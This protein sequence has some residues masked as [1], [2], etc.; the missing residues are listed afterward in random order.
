MAFAA[1]KFQDT[2]ARVPDDI[3]G[4]VSP[5]AK[6]TPQ[7]KQAIM[8]GGASQVFP[9]A[10]TLPTPG[11]TKA[12]VMSAYTPGKAQPTQAQNQGTPYSAYAPG[13]AQPVQQ[14][15]Y[16]TPYGF[17][18]ADGDGQ[19]DRRQYK[20]ADEAWSSKERSD[21][22]KSAASQYTKLYNKWS[23]SN[24]RGMYNPAPT[25]GADTLRDDLDNF[26]A[27]GKSADE[28][29]QMI[30]LARAGGT[31]DDEDVA[32]AKD[33][34]PRAIEKRRLKDIA[35][36]KIKS[37][38]F[39]SDDAWRESIAA[40]QY[41]DDSAVA[42]RWSEARKRKAESQRVADADKAK[43]DY[44]SSWPSAQTPTS[45]TPAQVGGAMP[46]DLAN[47]YFAPGNAQPTQAQNQGTPY[48]T[49]PPT[50]SP[51]TSYA[52]AWNAAMPK[53]GNGV[54]F[55][56]ARSVI[57]AGA[58]NMAYAAPDKRPEGF[59][60]QSYDLQGNPVT[61]GQQAQQRDAF[62]AQILQA[63]RETPQYDFQG[64]LGRAGDMVKD[65]WQ[66]PFNFAAQPQSPV[67]AQPQGQSS[68]VEQLFSP[69]GSQEQAG[70]F[71]QLLA[72][73]GQSRRTL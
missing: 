18:D 73:L 59:V 22:T 72:R 62:I 25:P 30:D 61:Q 44:F 47:K 52:D 69:A 15:S 17:P 58:G 45:E 21:Q 3:A 1:G 5:Y 54:Q 63:P 36:G 2:G 50:G 10:P 34:V 65:G 53:G 31:I 71:D 51:A 4:P 32:F 23:N 56:P 70:Y 49:L 20:T 43:T 64:M 39:S 48:G 67:P 35:N 41:A 28:L 19:D 14:Q 33:Y 29:W 42:D 12:P 9:S 24:T 40:N 55:T 27:R 57:G 68:A 11:S 37:S 60:T 8:A 46:P 66:N 7:Q 26:S 13:K 16:G 38:G 6:L